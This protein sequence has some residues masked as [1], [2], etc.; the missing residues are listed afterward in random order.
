MHIDT[1][2]YDSHHSVNGNVTPF[3]REEV[4][5]AI[6]S[7]NFNKG[8]GPDCF[9]GNVLHS[10]NQLKQ[11]LVEEITNALNVASIP[12]YLRTGRLVPLQ[13][14]QSKGPTKLDD[15]RPIVVRSHLS[16]IM[17]K[18]ILTKVEQQCPHL[19]SSKIYQTGFKEG[20][21]TAI[22]ASR[23]LYEVHGR[24]KRK[25]NLLIDLQKDMIHLTE[26]F[27]GSCQRRGAK[28]TVRKKSLDC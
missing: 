24:K 18:A 1:N 4:I 11:K 14:T 26:R 3:T 16:K 10:N 13:K 28:M 17:E 23:L 21:S 27:C 2:N 15:I 20:K 5:E 25:F 9:D 8:L 7:C 12:E 6:K 19:I 22:H